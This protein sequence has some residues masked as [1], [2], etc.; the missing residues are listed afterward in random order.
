M[1]P[2]KRSLSGATNEVEKSRDASIKKQKLDVQA[3]VRFEETT[4]S[5]HDWEMANGY[6]MTMKDKGHYEGRI[7][8]R[9]PNESDKEAPPCCH[10]GFYGM[11][12]EVGREENSKELRIRPG[13]QKI[14][15]DLFKRNDGTLV[16]YIEDEG[17]IVVTDRKRKDCEFDVYM[18]HTYD[19]ER[20]VERR[21]AEAI[22]MIRGAP[23]QSR[24]GTT[25]TRFLTRET[26][27]PGEVVYALDADS[28]D[29]DLTEYDCSDESESESEEE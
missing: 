15:H 28:C 5:E 22:L 7:K 21:F 17:R 12:C 26:I 14:I 18:V 1:S 29:A 25:K 27:A 8:R 19:F 24:C 16:A 13:R 3:L 6:K 23:C 11:L 10:S 9:I 4:M 2:S 20:G